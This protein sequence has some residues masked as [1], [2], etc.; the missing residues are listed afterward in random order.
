VSD[1]DQMVAL[2]ILAKKDGSWVGLYVGSSVTET[3]IH[4]ASI[5]VPLFEDQEFREAFL[6]L[7]GAYLLRQMPGGRPVPLDDLQTI[8][9]V[10]GR[11]GR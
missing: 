2:R 6:S 9:A 11:P 1:E 8:E 10:L 3:L 7:L 4:M 5:G